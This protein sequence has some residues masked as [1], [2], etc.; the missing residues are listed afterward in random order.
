MNKFYVILLISLMII[1]CKNGKIKSNINKNIIISGHVDNHEQRNTLIL[2]DKEIYIDLNGD[3]QDTLDMKNGFYEFSV[4][5]YFDDIYLEKGFEVELQIDMKKVDSIGA[6]KFKGKGSIENNFLAKKNNLYFTLH[7]T[8]LDLYS[9]KMPVFIE[10]ITKARE[11]VTEKLN[12]I[13]NA[14]RVFI[15]GQQKDIRYRY[16]RQLK[17]FPHL[18]DEWAKPEK[19]PELPNHLNDSINKINYDDSI[20]YDASFD[21]RLLT[22]N[23]FNNE[24]A[25]GTNN[26]YEVFQ[27]GIHFVENT[28]SNNIK[29]SLTENYLYPFLNTRNDSLK[30]SFNKL[31]NLATDASLKVKLTERFEKIKNIVKGKNSPTFENYE[32]HEGKRS[33]LKDFEGNYVY[34]DI[35]AT[36][37]RPCLDEIPFLKKLEEKY[38]DKPLKFV[39]ISADNN[40]DKDKWLKMIHEKELGGIQLF[41]DNSFDSKFIKQYAVEEIPR[42]ILACKC[43]NLELVKIMLNMNPNIIN[44]FGENSKSKDK[45]SK[46]Y[47]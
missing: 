33:S 32:T 43:N 36:W 35:W 46:N 12:T 22:N 21:Y 39:S 14:S 24:M 26:V 16:I 25:K 31:Y 42:F 34:V 2:G 28:K 30:S 18:H 3:F 5:D 29:T 6:T 19:Y 44:E 7:G 41:S 11:L 1:A 9:K 27:N 47:E 20:A 37:C 17:H 8:M 40:I 4:G 38:H 10:S 13:K 15:D 45:Y 23:H